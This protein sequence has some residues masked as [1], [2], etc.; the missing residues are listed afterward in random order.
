MEQDRIAG[1]ENFLSGLHRNN[2]LNSSRIS[3]ACLIVARRVPLAISVIENNKTTVRVCSLS[4]N[5][6]IALLAILFITNLRQ[7]RNNF[8][9]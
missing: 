1:I 3:P 6:V 4:E 2:S 8:S 5:Y 7:S 9:A